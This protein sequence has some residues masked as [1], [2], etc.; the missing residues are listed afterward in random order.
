MADLKQVFTPEQVA[1]F[2][3]NLK[4]SALAAIERGDQVE[5]DVRYLY[6]DDGGIYWADRA[7]HGS[8]FTITVHGG[9]DAAHG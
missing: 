3:D 2:C 1:A 4:V 8:R 6:W 7:Y 9:R 5:I